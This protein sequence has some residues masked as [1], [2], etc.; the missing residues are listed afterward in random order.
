[1]KKLMIALAVVACA[2]AVQASAYTWKQT[3]GQIFQAGSTSDL[4]AQDTT[5]Y[6]FNAGTYSQSDLVKALFIDKSLT[7]D[8]VGSKAIAGAN[9]TVSKSAT[10]STTPAW[11]YNDVAPDSTWTA[12]YAIVSGDNIFISEPSQLIT[13]SKFDDPVGI[14]FIS[15]TA[16]SQAAAMDGSK[17][18][19]TTGWYTAVPEPTSGL[20]LLLGVAGL[21]LRRRRA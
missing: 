14:S 8:Q 6:L 2:A 21:A 11:T 7:L 13:A 12:Y 16:A 19:T 15:P 9:G 4:V 20:L 18:Y 17:G 5:A 3:K 1:M 10:I